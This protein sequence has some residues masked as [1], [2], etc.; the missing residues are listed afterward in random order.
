MKKIL[1][2]L[3]GLIATPVLAQ[4]PM[5]DLFFNK[6]VS[7]HWFIYGVQY[8]PGPKSM[9]PNCYA[10]LQYT[11]GSAIEIR[12]DLKDSEFYMWVKPMSWEILDF[13][14]AADL[15]LRFNL[16]DARGRVVDGG[17]FV[18]NMLNKN[19]FVIR[20]IH[21]KSFLLSMFKADKAVLIPQDNLPN[22]TIP[23]EGAAKAIVNALAECVK[24][25]ATMPPP[26]TA[27]SKDGPIPSLDLPRRKGEEL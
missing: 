14:R 12:K 13:D 27:N 2:A 26:P 6:Q 1:I 10:S 19:T 16:H 11:D 21:E 20:G 25:S 15:H 3:I 7:P 4:T 22:L 8:P 18:Y 17:K 23:F 24:K 5:G 9:N